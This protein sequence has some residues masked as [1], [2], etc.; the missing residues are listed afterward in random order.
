MLVLWT[1]VLL[2]ISRLNFYVL[3]ASLCFSKVCSL[4]TFCVFDFAWAPSLFELRSFWNVLHF[5]D[6]KWTPCFLGFLPFRTFYVS[7][8]LNESLAFRASF[9]LEHFMLSRF[10][11]C[12][13]P[14]RLG[15]FQNILRFHNFK[16]VHCSS[17]FVSSGTFYAS[18]ISNEWRGLVP[19]V[20]PHEDSKGPRRCPLW[21]GPPSRRF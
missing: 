20:P 17:G 1:S 8:I 5:H 11:M 19:R 14:F 3:K 16:W 2:Y 13:L 4:Q 15:S 10:K 7:T 18:V 12:P 21:L 9:L 6:F